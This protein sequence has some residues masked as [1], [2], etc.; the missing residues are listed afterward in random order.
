MQFRECVSEWVRR[1]PKVDQEW[2][3]LLQ[4]LEGHSDWVNAVAFSPDDKLLA[5]AS[6]DGTVK[7]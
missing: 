3:A 2:N 5:S 6:N 1:L 7:L 4:T